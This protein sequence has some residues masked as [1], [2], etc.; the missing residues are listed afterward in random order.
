MKR[1]LLA[2]AF[3]LCAL[4]TAC[5]DEGGPDTHHVPDPDPS[6]SGVAPPPQEPLTAPG[7]EDGHEEVLSEG[8]HRGD[9]RF[10]TIGLPRG[11]LW[12]AV[13]CISLSKPVRFEVS[14]DG[15][16]AF[17]SKCAGVQV[18]RMGHRLTLDAAERT[19]VT[20]TT[21]ESVRW[22]ISVQVPRR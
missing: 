4:L 3:A 22:Y 2:A 14:L 5:T 11:E 7:A 15:V 6:P 1:S 10:G 19:R 9:R 20:V 8:P 21:E 17:T 16:M 12:V 13:N 18:E